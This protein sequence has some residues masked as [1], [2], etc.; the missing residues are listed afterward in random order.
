MHGRNFSLFPVRGLPDAK[1]AADNLFRAPAKSCAVNPRNPGNF[2]RTPTLKGVSSMAVEMAATEYGVQSLTQAEIER[3]LQ[4]EESAGLRDT[5]IKRYRSDL[6]KLQEYLGPEGDICHN[7]LK[8]WQSDMSSKGYAARTI[9]ARV[10]TVNRYLAFH[11]RMELCQEPLFQKIEPEAR[12][13]QTEYRRLLQ[14]AKV[15]G[16]KREELL[17]R[18]LAETGF[19]LQSIEQ[20]TVETVRLAEIPL[21]GKRHTGT[22]CLPKSLRHALLRYIESQQIL[23]GPVFVTHKGK[24]M[25]R[26]NI[27]HELQKVARAAGIPQEKGSPRCLQ[28]LCQVKPYRAVAEERVDAEPAAL[29]TA[30][31]SR[32][33]RKPAFR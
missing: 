31:S 12:L 15:Q 6:L 11:N 7:T 26:A 10:A 22:V 23:E 18:L 14:T 16:K 32:K 2:V 13:T 9:R 17:L 27:T 4:A 29:H 20:I 30:P 21:E 33:A 19:P 8:A 5:S 3:F 24:P 28:K 1:V 25:S